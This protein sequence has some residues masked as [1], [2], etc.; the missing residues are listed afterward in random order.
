M[1]A[2]I[3]IFQDGYTV[4]SLKETI[5]CEACIERSEGQKTRDGFDCP[6][7]TDTGCERMITA[8]SLILDAIAEGEEI[9]MCREQCCIGCIRSCG[10]RC[11]QTRI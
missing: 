2:P 8:K 10:Y 7:M 1:E 9:E 4:C 3:Q 11:G 6:Y 5:G